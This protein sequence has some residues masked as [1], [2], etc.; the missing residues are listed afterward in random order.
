MRGRYA[1]R[2]NA[3]GTG[4]NA[5]IKDMYDFAN[6]YLTKHSIKPRCGS[7]LRRCQRGMRRCRCFSRILKLVTS[8]FYYGRT[9]EVNYE[10][11][12]LQTQHIRAQALDL[13]FFITNRQEDG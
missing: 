7:I 11:E 9:A 4:V 1:Y 13:Q 3:A 12:K 6:D 2:T 5:W 8:R 10:N